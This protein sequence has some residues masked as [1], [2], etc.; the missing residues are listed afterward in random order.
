MDIL[1]ILDDAPIMGG[2]S[3]DLFDLVAGQDRVAAL[4]F[5]MNVDESRRIGLGYQLLDSW[6]R[7]NT[8][9]ALQAVLD[10]PKSTF[11]NSMLLSAVRDWAEEAPDSVLDRLLEI[12]RLYR[13]DAVSAV[14][15]QFA[16]ENPKN[17]LEQI[18][19]FRSVPGSHV[20]RAVQTILR[21]WSDDAPDLAI[22]WIQANMKEGSRDRVEALSFVI[23]QYALLDPERAMT[24]AVEEI[25]PED[26]WF[27]LDRQVI[28]ALLGRNALI[29]RSSYSTEYKIVI[30][31]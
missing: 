10:L 31:S 4:E 8:E 12:P 22:D 1:T 25:K 17:A 2:L 24:L 23:Y 11:R 6:S 16:L 21:S 26:N 20:D 14:A 18:E 5:I 30:N 3:E 9:E 7:F 15:N 13:A 19:V 27:D 28:H 29:Q